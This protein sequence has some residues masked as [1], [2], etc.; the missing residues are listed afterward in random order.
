MAL[1]EGKSVAL[2]RSPRYHSLDAWRGL[3]CVAIVV[4]HASLFY[5]AKLY[6]SGLQTTKSIAGHLLD[7][8]HYLSWGVPVFFVI[9]GYCISATADSTRYKQKSTLDYFI[10][11]FRRIFPPYWIV[12]IFSILLITLTDWI[13]NPDL[14][15]NGP[16]SQPS[17]WSLD[18]TQ[19]IGNIT[20]TETWRYHLFGRERLQ[21]VGQSWTLCYEEQFY[22]VVGLLLVISRRYFFVLTAVTS[23]LCVALHAILM[24]FG[25]PDDGFFFDGNWL[26]FAA[27]ILVYYQIN[28]CNRKNT[29]ICFSILLASFLISLSIESIQGLSV[30]TAYAMLLATTHRWDK[31]ISKQKWLA[32]LNFCGTMCYSLYLVHQLIVTIIQKKLYYLGLDSAEATLFVTIPVCTVV[33]LV[34]GAA[35]FRYVES[36]FLNKLA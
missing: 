24:R 34:A 27:G 29:Y 7:A 36:R 6:F 20:L 28:Y 1:A 33:S 15:R 10:R 31:E 26:L 21:F 22:F 16:R 17:P 2:P 5:Q 9:S 11:R 18:V 4:Y 13:A 14:L 8:C 19:W 30:G 32:P 25:I 3:A 35:Y 23:V 12:I